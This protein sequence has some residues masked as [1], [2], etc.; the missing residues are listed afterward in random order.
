MDHSVRLIIGFEF[1]KFGC[2]ASPMGSYMFFI[3]HIFILTKQAKH[4]QEPSDSKYTIGFARRS[5][6]AN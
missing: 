2:V 4:P 3:S 5:A 6:I 1:G